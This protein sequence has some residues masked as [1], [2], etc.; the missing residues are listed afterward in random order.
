MPAAILAVA[1][2]VERIINFPLVDKVPEEGVRVPNSFKVSLRFTPWLLLMVKLFTDL[3]TKV[4]EGMVCA[5][6]PFISKVPA[7]TSNVPLLAMLA[8]VQRQESQASQAP[9]CWESAECGLNRQAVDNVS[10]VV[11]STL[12][13]LSITKTSFAKHY[14]DH[15]P[16][17]VTAIYGKLILSDSSG[18]MSFIEGDEFHDT[19]LPPI[20]K[21]Q[22]T[23]RDIKFSDHAPHTITYEGLI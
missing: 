10:Y 21:Q 14:A 5:V 2:A 7:L 4:P 17:M 13:P 12:L 18:H 16:G 23:V 22:V 15:F 8:D 20:P 6:L 1:V 19:G 3:P 11:D 9:V